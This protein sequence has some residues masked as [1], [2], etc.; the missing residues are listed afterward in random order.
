M[1]RR[2]KGKALTGTTVDFVHDPRGAEEPHLIAPFLRRAFWAFGVVVVDEVDVF[3][4]FVKLRDG[5]LECGGVS[6][7]WH[8]CV[9]AV[10]EVERLRD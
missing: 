9:Q 10:F 2:E 4:V 1:R 7:A 5:L 8:F 6:W 3:D